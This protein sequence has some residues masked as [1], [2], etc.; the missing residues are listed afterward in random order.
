MAREGRQGSGP[1]RSV[2]EPVGR[3]G[4]GK[5]LL[6]EEISASCI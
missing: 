6:A 4:G 1:G 3:P 2:G 5:V